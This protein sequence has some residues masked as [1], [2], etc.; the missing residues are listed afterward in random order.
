LRTNAQFYI[1]DFMRD[2]LDLLQGSWAVA[3]LEMEGQTISGGMLANARVEITGNRFSSIGMG[4]VYEG[5]V[6]LDETANPHRLDMKFD[7]GPEKGNTNLGIYELDGDTWKICLAT[8]SDVRPT[9]FSAS[10]GSGFV[11]ETLTRS[12]AAPLGK[13]TTQSSQKAAPAS[14]GSLA[15]E[16]EGEWRMVSAVM[17]GQ[18]M[19]E[20]AVEWVKRVTHGNETIV[21]AGP[22][23]MM[24][25]EF[26]SDD[27]EY[28]KTI[29]YHNT[30]GSNKGKAQHGIYEFEGGLLKLCVAPP[31]GLRPT[32]FESIPGDKRTFTVWKRN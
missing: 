30:A 1:Y 27:S 8:R 14:V 26:T 2:D 5:I 16:F 21:Y 6:I 32:H 9:V 12:T 22:Q 18:P 20:S 13:D 31:G 11:F 24:K 29:D 15:T 17:D 4:S 28:P 23:V 3:E 7:A 10:A 19:E 25:V